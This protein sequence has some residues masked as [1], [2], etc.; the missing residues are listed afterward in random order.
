MN[1]AGPRLRTRTVPPVTQTC[2]GT[3]TFTWT[4]HTEYE[5]MNDVVVPHALRLLQDGQLLNNPMSKYS[6]TVTE[7]GGIAKCT[8]LSDMFNLYTFNNYPSVSRPR[9][10]YQ[11]VGFMS[12][13]SINESRI[14]DRLIAQAKQ[15]ALSNVDRTPYQFGEDM[16]ELKKSIETLKD[17]LSVMRDTHD[18]LKKGLLEIDRAKGPKGSTRGLIR[19]TN[20]L[21]KAWLGSRYAYGSVI[22]SAL[23]LKDKYDNVR[24]L[25]NTNRA[26]ARRKAKSGSFSDGANATITPYCLNG[27]QRINYSQDFK[28][29]IE[30]HAG[31]I[32][33]TKWLDKAYNAAG[34]D[35]GLRLKDMPRAAWQ[36]LP[37]TWFSDRFYDI[38]KT[39][40][41]SINLADPNVEILT[42]W[43][44]LYQVLSDKIT[45]VNSTDAGYTFVYSGSYQRD[46]TSI[47]R[48]VWFPE[49]RDTKPVLDLGGGVSDIPKVPYASALLLSRVAK[50]LK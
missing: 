22:Y 13:N 44:V 34:D 18:T 38:S 2:T 39:I 10:F 3:S 5:E 27:T 49:Y 43:V 1:P 21:S 47:K 42:A 36:V 7:V 30:A 28:Y 12:Q 23:N 26:G 4:S 46:M 9:Q 17:P 8:R 50:F 48:S 25:A 29:T 14:I 11:N 33:R 15:S 37:V 6:E 20:G 40:Q 24:M 31:I 32:Y 41:G 45:C 16:F 35:W 19:A